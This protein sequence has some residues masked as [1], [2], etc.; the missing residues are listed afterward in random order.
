[1]KICDQFKNTSVNTNGSHFLCGPY[2]CH[3]VTS[4][5][6]FK[7]TKAVSRIASKKGV[8]AQN[9]KHPNKGMQQTSEI[10]K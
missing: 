9:E 4:F 5:F 7:V 2:L 1:M 8:C 10:T 3:L 6:I